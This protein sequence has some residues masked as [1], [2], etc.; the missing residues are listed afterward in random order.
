MKEGEFEVYPFPS[1]LHKLTGVG[2]V[3]YP[4]HILNQEVL[5]EEKCRELA[6]TNDDIWFW[7]M[8]VL[9]GAKINVVRRN[10]P[11]VEAVKGTQEGAS[12]ERFSQNA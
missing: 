9:N 1:Y 5:D 12:L 2:G 7:L 4:P 6:P 10:L 3:L 8:A 11:R